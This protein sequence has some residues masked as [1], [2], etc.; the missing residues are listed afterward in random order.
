[1]QRH[2]KSTSLSEL[3][4]DTLGE[5]LPLDRIMKLMGLP[6]SV[7]KSLEIAKTIPMVTIRMPYNGKTQIP[8]L[9]LTP[10]HYAIKPLFN[11]KKFLG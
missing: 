2:L 6:L 7:D 1:M 5:T 9:F 10:D 11:L 8:T 3:A 4:S